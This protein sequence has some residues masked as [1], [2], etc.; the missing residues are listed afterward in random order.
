[1]YNGGNQQCQSKSKVKVDFEFLFVLPISICAQHDL[2][3]GMGATQFKNKSV[4]QIIFIP[5]SM[6]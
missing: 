2:L 3:R 6:G 5:M 4:Q 1:M